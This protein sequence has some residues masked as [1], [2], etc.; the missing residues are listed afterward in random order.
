MAWTLI[1]SACDAEFSDGIDAGHHEM[2]NPGHVVHHDTRT[3]ALQRMTTA[4]L[5]ERV[6]R[7]CDEGREPDEYRVQLGGP[8]VM[9]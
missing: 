4:E 6:D 8:T 7:F 5:T 2:D 1:C 3:P 9:R